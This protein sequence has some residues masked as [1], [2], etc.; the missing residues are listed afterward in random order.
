M[1]KLVQ[2]RYTERDCSRVVDRIH[3]YSRNLLRFLSLRESPNDRGAAG[4]WRDY[5]C[6][7]YRCVK[8]L[9][10]VDRT[11]VRHYRWLHAD[12]NGQHI[13]SWCRLWWVHEVALYHDFIHLLF[14][15]SHRETSTLTS[16]LPEECTRSLFTLD[17]YHMLCTPPLSFRCFPAHHSFNVTFSDPVFTLFYSKKVETIAF[18]KSGD[19][20]R[21]K[22][23]V[24][25]S[26][27]TLHQ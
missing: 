15:H 10:T 14:L 13:W 24:T 20:H 6:I 4:L 3:R 27:E 2:R 21:Q 5:L 7:R 9:M 23:N 19:D 18:E 1:S 22:F 12:R 8:V 16:E 25:W 17:S 26:T 11:K